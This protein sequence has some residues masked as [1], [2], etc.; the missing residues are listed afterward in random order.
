MHRIRASIAA[1]LTAGFALTA[2]A[3]E[4]APN[5][6]APP[7]P[8]FSAPRPD[9]RPSAEPLLTA[10]L[11]SIEQH[12]S[13]HSTVTGNLGFIGD[14]NAEGTVD[15]SGPE[16]DLAVTGSTR[17]ATGQARQPVQLTVVDGV[18]YLKSPLLRPH[19]DTPWLEITPD[20]PDFAA[21]L[22]SPALDQ[23]HDATDPRQAFT[24]IEPTVRIAARTPDTVDGRPATRYELRVV[25]ASAADTTPDPGQASRL[26]AQH[27]SGHG[28]LTYQL[29]ID[30]RGLPARFAA[31]Q[32]IAQAGQTTL[33]TTYTDWGTPVHVAPPPADKIGRFDTLGQPAAA[34]R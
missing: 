31:T 10:M 20:G 28:E 9:P 23:L 14:F 30:E 27:S 8:N 24:G 16:A 18:G 19:P 22:F 7:P 29:W 33:T 3:A 34:P 6:P 21:R 26:R 11:R 5:P 2:C 4:P 1:A 15:Y 32:D 13:A 17:P 25:T 12:G